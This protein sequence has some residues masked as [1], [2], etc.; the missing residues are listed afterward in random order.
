[1]SFTTI[2]DFSLTVFC[3][4]L[5]MS[6]MELV[7]LLHLENSFS[8]WSKLSLLQTKPNSSFSNIQHGKFTVLLP[9]SF[10]KQILGFG[11]Y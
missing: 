8:V 9:L 11:L 4:L 3:H 10:T 1:M 5:L 7:S 2:L 6:V